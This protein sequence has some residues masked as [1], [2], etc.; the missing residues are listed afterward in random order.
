MLQRRIEVATKRKEMGNKRCRD[1]T[2]RSQHKIEAY[3]GKKT[4]NT[5]TTKNSKSQHEVVKQTAKWSQPKN[6]C[7]NSK[8]RRIGRH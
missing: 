1:I 4:T 5:I 3:E 6:T 7:C 2:M 8:A